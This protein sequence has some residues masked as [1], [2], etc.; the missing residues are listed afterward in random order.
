MSFLA[1]LLNLTI[2]IISNSMH[3]IVCTQI[4]FVFDS[5][6]IIMPTYHHNVG[7][8]CLFMFLWSGYHTHFVDVITITT[9]PFS[10][11]CFFDLAS[12][13][14]SVAYG[15]SQNSCHNEI[16]YICALCA[17]PLLITSDCF[18]TFIF[19][20]ACPCHHVH[21]SHKLVNWL[22]AIWDDLQ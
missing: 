18:R 13:T 9:T 12:A 21:A 16:I 8:F 6:C 19:T 17:S 1:Y 2:N 14:N 10:G 22:S 11:Y 15:T 5:Y 4:E 7:H 3:D 20:Y